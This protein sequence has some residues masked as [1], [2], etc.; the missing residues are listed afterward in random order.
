MYV[1]V[2]CDTTHKDIGIGN[3]Q[4]DLDNCSVIYTIPSQGK[5]WLQIYIPA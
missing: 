3:T 5:W 2:D 4:T 1:L